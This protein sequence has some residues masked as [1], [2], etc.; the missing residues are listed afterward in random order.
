MPI[1]LKLLA[2][3]IFW[4]ATPTIG[5][6]LAAY[7]A[8]L[9]VVCGRFLVAAAFLLVFA[10]LGRQFARVPRRTWWRFA[11]LGVTGIVLHN[12]LMFKGLESTTAS[13]TSIILALIAIQV[14]ILDVLFYRRL[15]DAATTAGVVIGFL[16]TAYVITGGELTALFDIGLGRGELL[17]FG[18]GLAWAV[19]SV[20]GRDLLQH[21][22]PLLVTTYA[23]VAGVV[24]MLPFLFE[25]PQVTLAIAADPAALALIAFLG[26]LGSALAF[27]WYYQA[28]VTLGT[29]GAALYINLVPVFG[30]LS[31]A[32]FLGEPLDPALIGGGALVLAGL[33]LVNRPRLA[34][35]S[36]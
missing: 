15:P 17:I 30:V 10:W 21:Y 5:R 34:V 6:V 7:Q 22:S 1:H 2:A 18:S 20:L 9:V 36:A 31:A 29:V 25:R 12:A 19:Y 24:M 16:G 26:Y 4:G 32:L 8:P 35:A 23:T 11:A 3:A 13:T 28:V 33:M 14:V 27:L